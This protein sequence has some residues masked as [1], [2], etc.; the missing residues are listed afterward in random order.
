MKNTKIN[1]AKRHSFL[2]IALFT[3][4][5]FSFTAC[6]DGNNAVPE[7]N[8]RLDSNTLKFTAKNQTATLIATVT[9]TDNTAVDWISG[10][11]TVA[12]VTYDAEDSTFATV[13]AKKYGVT[14]ITA[15]MKD[16]EKRAI[17]A[18]IV[19]ESFKTKPTSKEIELIWVPSGT[20][21]MG[22]TGV[23]GPTHLVTLTGFFMGTKEVTQEQ[24]NEVMGNNPSHFQPPVT[25]TEDLKLPVEKVSWY[26]ALLFC[27]KL[28]ELEDLT[29]AYKI[30]NSTNVSDWGTPPTSDSDAGS[31]ADIKNK[32]DWDAAA[33]D[34][35]STGYRLPTEAQWEYAC[36]AGTTTSF[37]TGNMIIDNTGWY[38]SNSG[39]KTHPAGFKPK[40][41]D[42]DGND[43]YGN[44]FG[45]CDMHG[46]V[47]EW[48]WEWYGPYMTD[49]GSSSSGSL[50][51]AR[52]G[53]WNDTAEFLRSAFR[54]S[55]D[56][57]IRN[58][59]IGFRVVR[60]AS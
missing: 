57:Y 33:I 8:I 31:D 37:Y 14:T 46:N 18:V 58:Q 32:K 52:G 42:E 23:A 27:N 40:Y 7:P 29:P 38:T 12:T 15:T 45:L 36:R 1:C 35:G 56:P 28:S 9:D 43:A 48:C 39:N 41:K 2:T 59:S 51:V 19:Q 10:D 4:I 54:Y 50:R 11:D 30:K 34:A 47:L 17:C 60:P 49:P 25:E 5:L 53:G 13:T 6:E 16:G 24:Y 20:F 22:Q 44:A 3:A 55:Y 21:I 26:D